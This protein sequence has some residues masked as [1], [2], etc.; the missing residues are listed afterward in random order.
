MLSWKGGPQTG[1][2]APAPVRGAP[3]RSRRR[4]PNGSKVAVGK[5]R[6]TRKKLNKPLLLSF[7]SDY[8]K[9]KDEKRP[10]E[11]EKNLLATSG[12]D[13]LGDWELFRLF[14]LLLSSR[15]HSLELFRL[16]LPEVNR[17]RSLFLALG[18]GRIS[19]LFPLFLLFVF[20]DIVPGR[21]IDQISDQFYLR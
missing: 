18:A 10:R 7:N 1:A 8:L 3:D 9:G 6:Q 17:V 19:L 2:D 5:S 16:E 14:M 21:G 12:S 4:P 20:L 13:F 15:R 11:K